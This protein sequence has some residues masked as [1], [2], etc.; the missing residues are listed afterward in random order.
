MGGNLRPTKSPSA[1]TPHLC[2]ENGILHDSRRAS[3]DTCSTEASSKHMIAE[4]DRKARHPMPAQSSNS[5]ASHISSGGGNWE[6]L[7]QESRRLVT[8]GT[9][10]ST[11][12]SLV[13]LDPPITQAVLSEIDFPRLE[14]D[15]IL[16]HHLNFDPEVQFRVNTQGPQAEERREREIK[17]WHALATEIALSLEHCQRITACPASRPFPWEA[18]PRLPRLFGAVRDIL[19]HLSP[20][21]YWPVIDAR[22]DVGFLMQQL[23]HGIC[24]CTSLSDWL[25]NFLGRFGSPTR[26]SLLHTMTS[27]I[28]LGVQNADVD[29]IVHGL[30]DI[31]EILQGMKLVSWPPTVFILHPNDL[32][33]DI[34][35]ST[36]LIIR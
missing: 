13:S 2:T 16:R 34:C 35:P 24:N 29:S 32:T 5:F 20:S 14:K 26:D 30:I 22:L 18:A 25:G 6:Q 19:K 9:N 7:A 17:Y 4:K 11:D 27:A 12:F 1:K 15:L 8:T 31:F 10:Y 21:E 23:E 33:T 3:V 36:R 28:R